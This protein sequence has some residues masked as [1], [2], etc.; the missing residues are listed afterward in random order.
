MQSKVIKDN[1][2]VTSLKMQA[3]KLDEKT[4]RKEQKLKFSDHKV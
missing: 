1:D 2:V 3:E 4:K